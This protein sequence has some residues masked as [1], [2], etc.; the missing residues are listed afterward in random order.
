[1]SLIVAVHYR[2]KNWKAL[3]KPTLCHK[4]TPLKR[5]MTVI[6]LQTNMTN[7]EE[8]RQKHEYP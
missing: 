4:Q 5:H 7:K 3:E 1:M 8:R 6:I 2:S